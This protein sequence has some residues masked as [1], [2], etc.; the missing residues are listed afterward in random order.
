MQPY[1][2]DD[3]LTGH[4]AL[5]A[6]LLLS[7]AYWAELRTFLALAK[8]KSI[9]RT[10]D[11]LGLSKATVSRQL[12][13]LQDIHEGALYVTSKKGVHLTA[14]GERLAKMLLGFD[15]AL[16]TFAGAVRD[17]AEQVSGTV[18]LSVTDAIGLF[19]VTPA[20]PELFAQHP[21]LQAQ[22]KTPMNMKDL[23]ENQ[24]DI[25]VT[26]AEQKGADVTVRRLGTVHL[27]PMASRDYVERR[28]LPTLET[29]EAHDFVT[30]PRYAARSGPWEP[31]HRLL[32]RG[33]LVHEAD[34]SLTFG[35]MVKV[36]LGIGLA[37]S[38]NIIDPAAV[39]IDLG[40]QVSL[41][42][43]AT[44]LTERLELPATKVVFD[45]VCELLGPEVPA[46]GPE[47]RL[48]LNRTPMAANYAR[49]INTD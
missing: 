40:V 7:G 37:T 20:L 48:D 36:G 27:I 2:D 34:A 3:R 46:F 47:M 29:I 43:Y 30:T 45:L 42:I 16:S 39:P 26:F 6:E 21:R 35:M 11:L 23:R 19:I 24:T 5:D 12:Q 9:N 8:S 1:S 4:R 15:E 14:Q 32:A 13:R 10:A 49:I 33:R 28:G 22:I 38:F 18:R 25:L 41:P 17:D 44:A 31:W